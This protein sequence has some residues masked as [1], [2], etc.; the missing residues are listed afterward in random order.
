[1]TQPNLGFQ[2]IK[3]IALAVSDAQRAH[4]FYGKTLNLRPAFE[5][6]KV[7]GYFLGQIVLMLMPDDWY[8]T[9]TDMPN[10]R[11]TIATANA[12]DT[13]AALRELGVTIADPVQSYNDEF[14]VGSFIDSEGNKLW[15]CSP[16]QPFVIPFEA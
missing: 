11:I 13:E 12:L 8:G 16:S 5:E 1:M 4:H 6:G 2:D 10:P 3:V 14:D 9:P 7:V 15:F